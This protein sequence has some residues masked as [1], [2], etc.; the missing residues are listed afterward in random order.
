MKLLTEDATMPSRATDDLAGFDVYSAI[1]ITIP[2]HQRRSIPLD[3]SITPP[4]GMYT[5]IMPRSGLAYKHALDT[6]AGVIDRDYT[7]NVQVILHNAGQEDFSI[8]KGDRIT[9]LIFCHIGHPSLQRTASLTE[10]KRADNGFGST[11][12]INAVRELKEDSSMTSTLNPNSEPT[13]EPNDY[14]PN[15]PYDIFLS[16]DPFDNQLPVDIVL[17]GD[18]PTLGIIF[19]F[20]KYRNRLQ[21]INMAK[22]TPGARVH[23]WR[24]NKQEI[25]NIDDLK[26]A[27]Q[28]KRKQGQLKVTCCFAT[29]RS[30]G[31]HPH[32]GIPQLYFDQLNIIAK[33]LKSINQDEQSTIW[34]LQ[35]PSSNDTMSAPQTT[36]NPDAGQFFTKKELQKCQDWN[37]WQQSIYKMLDQYQGQRMFSDPVPLPKEKKCF[38]YAWGVL[39]KNV[40]NTQSTYGVQWQPQ[41]KRHHHTGARLRKRLGC[42]E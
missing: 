12:G 2:P 25:K 4:H 42:G 41:T 28:Q 39:F 9:Q 37:E 18:D 40:W 24:S 38:R 30:F 5:Q 20:C 33:H 1:D 3:I 10:T 8:T 26:V 29:D 23:K 32:H 17:K 34:S 19:Q 35:Q 13:S 27:I 22:S 21:L 36:D 11:G 16:G 31:I 7:G 6:K 14:V 15:L